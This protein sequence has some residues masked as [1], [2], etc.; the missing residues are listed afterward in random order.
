MAKAYF[1]ANPM[2]YA[3]VSLPNAKTHSQNSAI[4]RDFS[5]AGQFLYCSKEAVYNELRLSPEFEDLFF[6]DDFSIRTG[7]CR[8]RYRGLSEL[9]KEET[10]EFISRYREIL[11]AWIDDRHGEAMLVA[12]SRDK[13]KERI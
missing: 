13:N 4:W 1:N 7:E 8:K 3:L 2:R 10:I 5:I 9:D 11:Q 6:V 12:W